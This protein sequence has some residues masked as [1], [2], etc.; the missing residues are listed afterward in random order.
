VWAAAAHWLTRLAGDLA[1]AA[2]AVQQLNSDVLHASS[3][4][5]VTAGAESAIFVVVTSAEEGGYVFGA[6]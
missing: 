3:E 2:L 4:L 5:H 1:G 6:V